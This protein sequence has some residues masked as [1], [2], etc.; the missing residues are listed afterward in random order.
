M[1]K[2]TF[3]HV[4]KYYDFLAQVVFWG[5]IKRSQIKNL[6]S[7]DGAK[8]ILILG[9]GTGWLLDEIWKK[10][11]NAHITY[12]EKSSK[13][14]ARAQ[15]RTFAGEV[16][17]HNADFLDTQST[18]IYDTI[19]CNYFLDVFIESDLKIV[20][21]KIKKQLKVGG[22]I[23]FTDFVAGKN[24]NII[25]QTLIKTMYL[26]FKCTKALNNT[27]LP[28]YDTAFA[29]IGLVCT[30]EEKYFFNMIASRIYEQPK[31][32]CKSL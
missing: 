20:V 25:K 4:A 6:Q 13:M 7:L 31:R 28:N 29:N 11:R 32:I 18:Q 21:Q 19:I 30:N 27:T 1:T 3:N 10:N 23:L 14:I 12:I 24:H 9:G 26:F 2:Q 8:S 5:A 16:I 22:K 17:F 15:Q